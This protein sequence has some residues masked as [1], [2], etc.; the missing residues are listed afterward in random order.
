MLKR[1]KENYSDKKRNAYPGNEKSQAMPSLTTM[2]QSNQSNNN[3]VNYYNNYNTNPNTYKKNDSYTSSNESYSSSYQPS[4]S[5]TYQSSYSSS[6]QPNTNNYAQQYSSGF[7]YNKKDTLDNIITDS[8]NFESKKSNENRLKDTPTSLKRVSNVKNDKKNTNYDTA[9]SSNNNQYNRGGGYSSNSQKNLN[10]NYNMGNNQLVRKQNIYYAVKIQSNFRGYLIRKRIKKLI[11]ACNRAKKGADKL[12]NIF[13]DKKKDAFHVIAIY[14]KKNSIKLRGKISNIPK[15]K[16]NLSKSQ[17]SNNNQKLPQETNNYIK[18]QSQQI[19]KRFINTNIDNAHRI[20][21]S[22]PRIAK[23]RNSINLVIKKNYILKYLILKKQNKLKQ[24]LRINFEKYKKNAIIAKKPII[25]NKEQKDQK[26]KKEKEVKD[27]I[28]KES[29]NEI[30]I[31]K[32]RDI[33]KKKIFRT[34]EIIHREFIKYYYKALYIHLNWYM[35]VVNQLTYTQNYYTSLYNNNSTNTNNTVPVPNNIATI[36]NNT[37]NTVTNNTKKNVSKTTS[38]NTKNDNSN[39]PDPLKQFNQE[40]AQAHNSQVNNALRESIMTIN[41]MNSKDTNPDEALRESIMSINKINDELSKEAQ[42]KKLKERNKHLKDLVVKRLKELRN[43]KHHYFMKFYY[44]GKL[45]EQEKINEEREKERQRERE[46]EKLKAS[47]K[48][49]E[50]INIEKGSTKLRG[51][52]K[53]DALDRRNKARN[54]RKL[55]MKKEKEKM[56]RLKFYFLK[57]HSNGMLFQLKKNAKMNYFSTKNVLVYPNLNNVN[58]NML[59]SKSE[60]KELTYVD[61]KMMERQLEKERLN[62]QRIEKLKVLFYKLDR[63][64]MLTKK[65][66]FEKWNLRAKIL[67]LTK[68]SSADI[69]KST[70]KKK[71]RNRKK[72]SKNIENE[73]KNEK[74]SEK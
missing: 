67:S 43:I 45:V 33:V 60:I 42:E 59:P 25:N 10:N 64:N 54:L 36:P 72:E 12:Q 69:K 17:L 23:I 57:F 7:N 53:D 38:N 29:N 16:A 11:N 13:R 44:Q 19:E 32:L 39:D 37:K 47:G 8:Y 9:Y 55:M 14:D 56:E 35:Y 15:S 2:L 40:N 20:V 62:T 24:I 52:K 1:T 68:I 5:S 27:T 22:I 3:N 51:R 58:L 61:K 63:H 50:E 26:E 49:D 34:N 4:Y 21:I 28:N 65:K 73:K 74:G 48:T 66:I 41:K 18:S 6:Y 30:K 46:L 71:L 31:K 70:K